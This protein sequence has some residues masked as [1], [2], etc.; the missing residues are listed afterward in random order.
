[1]DVDKEYA[2]FP[3]DDRTYYVRYITLGHTTRE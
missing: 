1:M 3:R 2:T